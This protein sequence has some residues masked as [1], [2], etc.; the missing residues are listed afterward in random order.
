MRGNK[1]DPRL[2]KDKT[3]ICKK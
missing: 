1:E 2:Q 3:N